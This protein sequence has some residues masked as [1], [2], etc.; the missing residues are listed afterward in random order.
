[1]S[2]FDEFINGAK[3][4]FDTASEKTSEIFEATK[5]QVEKSQLNCKLS[6]EYEK[7]G[8]ACFKMSETGIDTTEKM[9]NHIS[10][11][12]DIHSELDK[13]GENRTSKSLSKFCPNCNTIFN[14]KYTFCPIC[15]EKLQEH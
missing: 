12:K 9:K 7:L 4:A 5:I 13:L 1:M 3:K 6:N 8:K 2:T 11:I 14:G 10:R 15:G